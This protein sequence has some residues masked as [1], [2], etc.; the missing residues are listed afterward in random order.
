MK[1]IVFFIALAAAITG[2][3][4]CHSY[5][6]LSVNQD[7]E[8]YRDKKHVYVMDLVTQRDSMVYFSPGFP[9]KLSDNGVTGYRQVPVQY[10][11]SDSALYNKKGKAEFV[12]KDGARY[13]VIQSADNTLICI[14]ADITHIPY[15]DIKEMQIKQVDKTRTTV[16]ILGLSG[17]L[18]WLVYFAVTHLGYDM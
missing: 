17:S 9:G 14:E 16:L 4:S 13:R 6:Y 8:A 12:M 18:V 11:V 15:S 2:L 3:S 1:K 5:K 7:Y 10:F